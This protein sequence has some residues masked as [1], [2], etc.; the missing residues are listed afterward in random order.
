MSNDQTFK[1]LLHA[2]FKEF[3][4]LFFPD[5]SS[6]LDFSTVSF[7]EQELFTDIPEGKRRIIDVVASVHT[8]DGQPE[9]VLVHVEVEA[10][11]NDAFP[12]RMYKYHMLLR[13]RRNLPVLPIAIFL[14]RGAGGLVTEQYVD[15]VFDRNVNV[16]SYDV[17]ALRDLDADD[18]LDLPNPLAPALSALMRPSKMGKVAQKFRS[19]LALARSGANDAQMVL[20]TN[21]VETYLKLNRRDTAKFEK[22]L[23][24]PENREVEM[25]ISV[26]EE[27]GIEKG[28]MRGERKTLILQ[29]EHKF[30]T[31]SE[32]VRASIQ[33]I[34][35]IDELDRLL[36]LVLTA[37]S[38]EEM[39]L[40]I[41]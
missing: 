32:N 11:P 21:V 16:F 12:E 3:F 25:V 18:Y 8:L 9:I 34:E 30:G 7:V 24:K 1:D 38:I 33:N 19:L 4:D 35:N 31:L 28:L 27:R 36:R 20:L 22:L 6:R 40:R 29:M 41:D 37:Q 26:Y 17:V 10:D 14:S 5:V 2:F 13:L 15:R 23:S 39:G